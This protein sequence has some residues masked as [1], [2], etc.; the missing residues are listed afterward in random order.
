MITAKFVLQS[1]YEIS[2]PLPHA[3]SVERAAADLHSKLRTG[4][5]MNFDGTLIHPHAISA[6]FVDEVAGAQVL[7]LKEEAA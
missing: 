7:H 5:W 6:V 1:G 3:S 2:L 4:H